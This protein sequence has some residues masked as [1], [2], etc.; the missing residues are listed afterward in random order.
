[1]H[2]IEEIDHA[3]RAKIGDLSS[4]YLS[5]ADNI[6]VKINIKHNDNGVL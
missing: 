1:M 6:T 4:E 2:N 3:A 5:N